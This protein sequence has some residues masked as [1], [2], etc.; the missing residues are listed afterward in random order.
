MFRVFE[1]RI[2]PI[3]KIPI[4]IRYYVAHGSAVV[5]KLNFTSINSKVCEVGCNFHMVDYGGYGNASA[6]TARI[7]HFAVI[8]NVF[9]VL[10]LLNN[11]Y[12]WL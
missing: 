3:T 4:I 8:T 9:E 2:R 12:V 7:V 10:R 11:G 6:R 5:D 1:C